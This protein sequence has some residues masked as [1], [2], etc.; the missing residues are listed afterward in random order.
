MQA[1]QPASGPAGKA[2][3]ALVPDDGGVVPTQSSLISV[4]SHLTACASPL[5]GP[6]PQAHHQPQCIQVCPEDWRLRVLPPMQPGRLCCRESDWCWEGKAAAGHPGGWGAERGRLARYFP[7]MWVPDLCKSA[8]ALL[9]GAQALGF[10]SLPSGEGV[11]FPGCLDPEHPSLQAH[12][13]Q[14]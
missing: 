1:W 10:N 4:L 9:R 3:P 11:T 5:Q 7:E 13:T 8:P 6:W 14:E 12:I 2:A